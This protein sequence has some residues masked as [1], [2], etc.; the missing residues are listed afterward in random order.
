L[1]QVLNADMGMFVTLVSGQFWDSVARTL[2]GDAEAIRMV[3]DRRGRMLMQG[4]E[5]AAL[6]RDVQTCLEDQVGPGNE[7]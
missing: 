7:Q 5:T 3:R 2:R 1:D 6:L 4:A